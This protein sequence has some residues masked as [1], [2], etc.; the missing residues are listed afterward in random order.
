MFTL[1]ELDEDPS[2]ILDLKDDVREECET[3]G[4]VTNVVLWDVSDCRCRFETCIM[5]MIP[6]LDDV[7]GTRRD[8]DCQIWKP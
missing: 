3:L 6:S 2:L 5:L 8:H 4:K 7:E 1:A